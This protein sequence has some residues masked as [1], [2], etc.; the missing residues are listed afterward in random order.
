MKSRNAWRYLRISRNVWPSRPNAA[1]IIDPRRSPG[2][3]G[4]SG[5]FLNSG[6]EKAAHQIATAMNAALV[7]A[8]PSANPNVAGL[9]IHARLISSITPPLR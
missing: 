1:P 8:A 2:S 6:I 7:A 4:G 5:T 9:M 3:V